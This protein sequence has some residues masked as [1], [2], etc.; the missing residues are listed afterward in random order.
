MF[1]FECILSYIRGAADQNV[2]TVI[3]ICE[4]IRQNIHPD[5]VIQNMAVRA[6]FR[7]M[8]WLHVK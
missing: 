7:I 4:M 3:L 6:D 8:P 1:S 5:F 2:D